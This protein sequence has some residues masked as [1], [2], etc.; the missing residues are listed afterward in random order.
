[1]W[2]PPWTA[3]SA[4]GAAVMNSEGPPNAESAGA[5][6]VRRQLPPLLAKYHSELRLPMTAAPATPVSLT[7]S[8]KDGACPVLATFGVS[9]RGVRAIASAAGVSAAEV[10]AVEAAVAIS[11]VI[12]VLRSFTGASDR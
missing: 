2:L 5:T 7:A 11:A 10:S 9:N 12:R 3:I 4:C 1:V 6:S 8:D